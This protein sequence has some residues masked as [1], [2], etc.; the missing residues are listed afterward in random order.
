[1]TDYNFLGMLEEIIKKQKNADPKES[2]TARLWQEGLNKITQ[3]FGEESVE[4]TIAALKEDDQRFISEVSDLLYHLLVM[5]EKKGVKFSDI[6]AEL[7]Q[8][9]A[10]YH[11]TD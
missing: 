8:R 9:N 1:M 5:V 4:V 7:K 11:G 2:Y 3:K 6:M 10:K